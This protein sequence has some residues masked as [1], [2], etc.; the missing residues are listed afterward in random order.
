MKGENFSCS[1]MSNSLR[2]Q[3]FSPW[4]FPGHNT[5]V[6]CH[7][8]SAGDLPSPGTEPRSATL[9]ANSL[10]LSHQGSHWL[11]NPFMDKY[12]AD[13]KRINR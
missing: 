8:L 1:V 3:L 6:D 7:S 13:S 2:P 9:Q 11:P 12:D 4:N 10:P 5:G